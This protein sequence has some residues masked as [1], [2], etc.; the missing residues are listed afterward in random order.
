MHRLITIFVAIIISYN[1]HAGCYKFD[2]SYYVAR[3]IDI[4]GERRF[5]ELKSYQSQL[6]FLNAKFGGRNWEIKNNNIKIKAP[7]IAEYRYRVPLGMNTTH[8]LADKGNIYLFAEYKHHNEHKYEKLMELKFTQPIFSFASRDFFLVRHAN[9]FIVIHDS[10]TNEFHLSENKHVK[11]T[12]HCGGISVETQ[13]EADKL[14]RKICNR[15]LPEKRDN[16]P[17]CNRLNK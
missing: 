15:L 4:E 14:N 9:I 10:D 7:D 16:N 13:D 1:S 17:A 3:P 12:Y 2:D 11:S 8:A 5:K 6:V